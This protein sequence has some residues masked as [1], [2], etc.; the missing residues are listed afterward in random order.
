LVVITCHSAE[1]PLTHA[2]CVTEMIPA[3]MLAKILVL[4]VLGDSWTHVGFVAEIIN[5]AQV[6]TVF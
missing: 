2:E 4:I 6:V 5:L 3:A 1:K